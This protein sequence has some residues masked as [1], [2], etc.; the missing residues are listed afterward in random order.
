MSLH[1]NSTILLNTVILIVL[2]LELNPSQFILIVSFFLAERL[3]IV[4]FDAILL[5]D[6]EIDLIFE[7]I[8]DGLHFDFNAFLLFLDA[9]E[10]HLQLLVLTLDVVVLTHNAILLT[11][12]SISHVLFLKFVLLL[13]LH[14]SL[15]HVLLT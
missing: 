9:A 15:V 5:V 14:D 2:I 7:F 3:L 10:F 8:V 11:F 1:S 6:E 12:E 13:Q 4:A